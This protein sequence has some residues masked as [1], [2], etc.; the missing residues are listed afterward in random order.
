MRILFVKLGSI[1]DIVHTLPALKAV[2]SALPDAEISWVVEERVAEILRG[3]ELIDNLIEV[4]TRALR[5]FGR[6]VDEM[7]AGA[8]AQIRGLRSF[9]FDVAIDLQGLWK[10]ALV[11]KLSGAPRRWGFSRE[12]LR[13]PGSRVLLTDTVKTEPQINVVR[14]NLALAAG[15]LNIGVPDSGFEFPITTSDEHKREAGEI[16]DAAGGEFAILNPSGGWV[17]KLWHAEK[18]GA[19]ADRLWEQ[20]GIASVVVTGPGEDELA[21]RVRAATHSG[22]TIFAKPSLKG[23]YE[24]AK[25]A[26][27]FVGGDTGPTHIAVAAGAPVVGLFGPTEWW[28]NG[29]TNPADLVVERSDIACRIDCHRRTCTNWICMDS[30]VDA[31]F[32]AVVERIANETLAQLA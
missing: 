25:R 5:D 30:D 19:L 11:A 23:L 9:E 22:R 12:D 26:R 3:N 31:V 29:S 32:D 20:K 17:T 24:L 21:E 18:F 1:G 10:S 28:R 15:A 7:I 4:D 8:R 16:T 27:V 14:K 6:G 13:E 2:R